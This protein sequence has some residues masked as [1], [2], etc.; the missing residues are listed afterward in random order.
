MPAGSKQPLGCFES[1]SPG[2]PNKKGTP[3][4]GAFLNRGQTQIL[5]VRHAALRK[6][7]ST[8]NLL[9]RYDILCL[10]AFLALRDGEFDLLALSE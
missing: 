2:A 3:L 5:F 1:I 9:D 8:P 7:G 6:R 10:R 4:R